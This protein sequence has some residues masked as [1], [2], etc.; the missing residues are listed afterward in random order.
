MRRLHGNLIEDNDPDVRFIYL[1][2]LEC[3]ISSWLTDLVVVSLGHET[4]KG[5]LGVEGNPPIK[6]YPVLGAWCRGG[7]PPYDGVATEKCLH[8]FSSSPP[9]VFD[10]DSRTLSQAIPTTRRAFLVSALETKEAG[11]GLPPVAFKVFKATGLP[12][13][14]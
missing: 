9:R 8:Y 1:F 3:P 10:F 5:P 2:L 11:H 13:L 14:R 4:A 12:F 6:I 7:T